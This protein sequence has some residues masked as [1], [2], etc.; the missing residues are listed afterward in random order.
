[1]TSAHATKK[2]RTV[3]TS[4]AYKSIHTDKFDQFKSEVCSKNSLISNGFPSVLV[5]SEAKTE[6]TIFSNSYLALSLSLSHHNHESVLSLKV[7]FG[8][9]P[10]MLS[11][12]SNNLF[13]IGFAIVY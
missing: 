1:M 2:S 12:R 9:C 6:T 7:F 8:S 11:R 3:R 13:C 10:V 5:K 4:H